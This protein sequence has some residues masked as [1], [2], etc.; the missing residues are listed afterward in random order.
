VTASETAAKAT[1]EALEARVLPLE[2]ALPTLETRAH[3]ASSYVT[4]RRPRLAHIGDSNSELYSNL[5]IVS[6]YTSG[7]SPLAWANAMLGQRFDVIGPSATDQVFGGSGQKTSDWTGAGGQYAAA[8]AAD[9]DGYVEAGGTNDVDNGLLAVDVAAR[10]VAFWDSARVLGRFVVAMT[11]PPL[12][13]GY[14]A[15][16]RS[17]VRETNRLLKAAAATRRGV[18][19]ADTYPCLVV[20][21]TGA[22]DPALHVADG[23]HHNAA[24]GS[25][26]GRVLADVLDKVLPPT[27]SVDHLPPDDFSSK[28]VLPNGFM[29][30]SGGTIN[31]EGAGS[32]TVP[33]GWILTANQPSTTAVASVVPCTDGVAGNWTQVQATAGSATPWINGFQLLAQDTVPGG[34]WNVGDTVYAACEVEAD[35]AGW[36]CRGLQ[37]DVNCFGPGAYG[38]ALFDASA[39]RATVTTPIIRPSRL[40]LVSPRLVVPAGTTRLQA[41]FLFHG[42]GTVRVRRCNVIRA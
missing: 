12:A 18:Y 26:A 3:A 11:V 16:E 36:D 38:A 22:A 31:G 34:R 9:V 2:T 14:T 23:L 15:D 28:V 39:T 13:A 37:I 1:S 4:P 42:G 21:S 30:G 25:R 32:G 10:R 40:V 41:R 33:A 24:G 6:P 17:Q 5:A 19:V 27:Q 7:R 8:L 20:P 29:V 35:A